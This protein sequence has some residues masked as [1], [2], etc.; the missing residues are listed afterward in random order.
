MSLQAVGVPVREW[1][2]LPEERLKYLHREESGDTVLCELHSA[3]AAAVFVIFY[4]WRGSVVSC[5]SSRSEL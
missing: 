3:V 1:I 2:K 5:L 4:Y